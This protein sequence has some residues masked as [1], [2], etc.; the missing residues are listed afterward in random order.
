MM[1]SSKKYSNSLVHL[2]FD[3]RDSVRDDSVCFREGDLMF[4]NLLSF[5]PDQTALKF[6]TPSRSYGAHWHY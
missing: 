2:N 6:K 3:L 4:A 1:M 5:S